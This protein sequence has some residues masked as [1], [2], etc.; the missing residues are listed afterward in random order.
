MTIAKAIL[1][2]NSTD[3]SAT[4]VIDGLTKK[5]TEEVRVEL[6]KLR[7]HYKSIRG[8]KD[9]QSAFLRLAD[10]LAGFLRDY[11]EQQSYAAPIFRKLQKHGIL[12]EV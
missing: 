4:I 2:K 3:Y 7:I 12:M 11:T 10:C 1:A 5:N 6:K 9:G 8:L